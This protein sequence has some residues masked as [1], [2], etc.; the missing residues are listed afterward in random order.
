[1]AS[2][3]QS[4]TRAIPPLDGQFVPQDSQSYDYSYS[5]MCASIGDIFHTGSMDE[6]EYP[7][8]PTLNHFEE[9]LA[10]N[11]L[12]FQLRFP[13]AYADEVPYA[14]EPP[15]M[16][17]E[18]SISE[19]SLMYPS[20]PSTDAAN[21]SDARYGQG[22]STPVEHPANDL[23]QQHSGFFGIPTSEVSSYAS[24][25]AVHA[26]AS[27]SGSV[28][29]STY[30][31]IMNALVP[32]EPPLDT[33]EPLPEPEPTATIDSP[34]ATYSSF[35]DA[36]GPYNPPPNTVEP[37]VV[38]TSIGIDSTATITTSTS[39]SSSSPSSSS[40]SPSSPPSYD[41]YPL[42][43]LSSTRRNEIVYCS[44]LVPPP[45]SRTN[46]WKCPYCSYTQTNRRSPDL[47]RHI[48]THTR[49]KHE[50]LWVCCGVPLIDAEEEHGM[51]PEVVAAKEPFEYDGMFMVGGC[52][53]VFSRRDALKR[54]LRAR[55]GVCYGDA[56]ASYQPGN[57]IGAR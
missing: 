30:S 2:S 34:I 40:P 47:K 22:Y 17:F 53:Q 33:T 44:T 19:A 26:E 15:P 5:D 31:T 10:N 21:Y 46:K 13:S 49:G 24:P 45:A 52:R 11:Y 39:S 50:A 27:L 56:M 18:T 55:R 4:A 29:I 36:L 48:Q 42:Q 23:G 20:S 1:M 37:M 3:L 43:L 14:A 12:A 16:Y 8:F 9:E 41:P 38:S 6:L 57:R 7:P 25:D 54:H 28:P 51:P 35:G 32:C